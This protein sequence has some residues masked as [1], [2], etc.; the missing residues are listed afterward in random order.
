MVKYLITGGSGFIGQN[1]INYLDSVGLKDPD[2]YVNVDIVPNNAFCIEQDVC[3]GIPSVNAKHIIHLAAFTDVRKSIENPSRSFLENCYGTVNCLDLAKDSGAES[4]VFASSVGASQA[5]SPYGASKFAGEAV[6]RAY[7]ESFDLNVCIL[8]LSNVYGP[9]SS[10]KSSV[11]AKFIKNILNKEPLQIFGNG[12]QTR[13]FVFVSDVVNTITSFSVSIGEYVS[14]ASGR[15]YSILNLV[16]I[17]EDLSQD[18]SIPFP[19]V[20]FLPSNKGEVLHSSVESNIVAKTKFEDG[21][22]ETFKW[23]LENG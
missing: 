3:E 18:Y 9:Y 15:S 6:C 22:E 2:D 19:G 14:V 10:H 8:R 4:F 17:L 5:C 21:V 11:V 20:E 13:D 23:F 16:E 1:L 7:R 12:K